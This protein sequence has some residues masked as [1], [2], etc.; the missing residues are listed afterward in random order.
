MTV[1]KA[2]L[3]Y[4][5]DHQRK[6]IPQPND[7]EGAVANS[8]AP[9]SL[10]FLKH[11]KR[12]NEV[13]GTQRSDKQNPNTDGTTMGNFPTF[14]P[15]TQTTVLG[16]AWTFVMGNSFEPKTTSGDLAISLLSIMCGFSS[17]WLKT[18]MWFSS[19]PISSMYGKGERRKRERGACQRIASSGGFII[20]PSK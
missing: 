3:I 11:E 9:F 8:M 7:I 4:N 2:I 17:N 6:E 18:S 13:K 1:L 14:S 16:L 20:I 5:R 19:S 10:R 12:K 15:S